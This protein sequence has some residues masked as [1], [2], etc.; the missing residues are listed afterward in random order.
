MGFFLPEMGMLFG[1]DGRGAYAVCGDE[2]VGGGAV[3]DLHVE[4]EV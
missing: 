1:W 2:D 3:E 4:G